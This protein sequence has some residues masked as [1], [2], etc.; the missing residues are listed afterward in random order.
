MENGDVAF[1]ATKN[2]GGAKEL[3]ILL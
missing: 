3:V 1:F 2:L